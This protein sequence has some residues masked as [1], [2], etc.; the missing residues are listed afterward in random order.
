MLLF[1]LQPALEVRPS[2][3]H[4]SNNC[5]TDSILLSMEDQGI[6]GPVTVDVREGLCR[7]VRQYLVMERG[8][9]PD[10]D[11]FFIA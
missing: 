6:I 1:S 11:P 8:L 10:G 5:L 4:G 2:S 3:S 7:A 9:S